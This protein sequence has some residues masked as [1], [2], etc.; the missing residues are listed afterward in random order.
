MREF[1]IQIEIAIL[2]EV[3]TAVGQTVILK[4]N[5]SWIKC[6]SNSNVKPTD[7]A[8]NYSAGKSYEQKLSV[9]IDKLSDSDKAKLPAGI[10][11]IVKLFD[12]NGELV[13]GDLSLPC[14]INLSPGVQYDSIEISRTA[15]LPFL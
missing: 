13:W 10:K 4:E 14:R 12:D 11:A 15:L 7:K 9:K 3:E 2:P 5:C 1:N 6:S 8:K